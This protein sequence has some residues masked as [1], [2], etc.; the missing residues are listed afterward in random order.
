MRAGCPAAKRP[1]LADAHFKLATYFK[2]HNEPQLAGEHWKQAQELNPDNWNYHR[3]DWS[4]TQDANR[5]WMAKFR[6]PGDKPYDAP[7]KLPAAD[8]K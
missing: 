8:S 5:N 2:E 6:A 3:Q 1:E 4:F 7:L